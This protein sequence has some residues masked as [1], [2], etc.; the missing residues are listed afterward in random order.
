MNEANNPT[1]DFGFQ[2]IPLGEKQARVDDVFHKVAQKYDIMNDFMSLGLHRLWKD[3]MVNALYINPSRPFH[4]LDVAG[5]TGD[6]SFR[7]KEI[8]GANT[9]VTL[10]DI[11]GEML[12]E[13]KARAEKLK[14]EGLTIVQ[15]TAEDLPFPDKS[16]DG[17]TIAFGIRNVPRRDKA[18]KEAYRVLK[19]GGRL[20]ILEFKPV[21]MPILDTI[22]E[23]WSMKA[24][25]PIGKMVM[26]DA[27]P[28]QYLV[29]SIRRF[30]RPDDFASQ[31]R[32]AGFGRVTYD[33]FSGGIV[34]LHK[35]WRL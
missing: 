23:Q 35:G 19:T 20:C 5:G 17:Y 11:N 26:G 6:I 3:A 4:H 24:I 8:G 31:I 9:S 1:I 29:E 34:A 16:F 2:N 32:D 13:G 27:E 15:G 10:F 25:P 7:V 33:E 12:R 30:P 28:Y 14:L 22:Y 18:L 21:D